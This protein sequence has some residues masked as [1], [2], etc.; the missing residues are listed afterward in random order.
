MKIALFTETYLPHVNGVVTHI[1]SLKEGLEALGHEVLVVTSDS[2]A[3]EHYIK[4]N[5]LYCP[6]IVAKRFYEYSLSLPY[7]RDR[8]KI[9]KEFNPDIIHIHNEFGIGLFGIFASKILKVPLVYTL[10][11]MYDDYLYYVFPKLLLRPAKRAAHLY[12]KSVANSSKAITGPSQKVSNFLKGIGVEKDVTVIPNS[13]EI[14]IFNPEN[15]TSEQ[16]DA[17]KEKYNIPKDR[18]LVC[19]CGRLGKE[20]SVDVLLDFWKQTVTKEDKM[21]LLLIGDGPSFDELL[22]QARELD[23][24]DMVTFTGKILHSEIPPYYAASD[25]YITASLSEMHSVSML[26]GMASGLPVLSRLDPENADQ[27]QEGI[28]GFIYVTP[29]EM[30]E[31]LLKIRD[32]SSEEKSELKKTV[33]CTVEK[34]GSED[35]ANDLLCVYEQLVKKE[36]KE[37]I[38]IG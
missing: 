3:K 18:M 26:E 38:K 6:G 5:V 27:I 1:K 25:V 2:D 35:L 34:S 13:A 8:L 32:M 11:T 31:Q 23:I 36:D 37:E 30:Y 15:F 21:H 16:K 9:L 7:S 33:R 12:F 14:D 28:N 10:H 22:A 4:D 19:F 29:Q 24:M 20:K 17:L